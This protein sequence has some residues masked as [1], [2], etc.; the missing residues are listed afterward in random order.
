MPGWLFLGAR[1]TQPLYH[2]SRGGHLGIQGEI[3]HPDLGIHGAGFPKKL[4]KQFGCP[5]RAWYSNE[6]NGIM[7]IQNK[8]DEG[9]QID[10]ESYYYEILKMDSDEPA[11]PG[12]LGRIVITDLYNYA[13]PILRYDNGDTAVAS[14][15]VKDGK[16]KLYLTKLYGRRSDLIYDCGGKALTPYIIT[17]NMWDV[18]RGEAVSFHSGGSD[19]IYTVA[20]RRQGADEY[21]GHHTSDFTV[22]GG[23]GRAFH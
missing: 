6:E 11:A 19:E 9:Y 17:N 7:G 22:S 15:K 5:V 2:K 20:E 14:R 4:Q 18:R 3:D 13:F 12:E 23:T 16:Y 10:T 8:E 21:R 1:R